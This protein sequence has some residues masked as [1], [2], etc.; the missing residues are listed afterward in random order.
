VCETLIFIL[1]FSS[2]FDEWVVL[3]D[4]VIGSASLTKVDAIV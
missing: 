1:K 4:F 3:L 2:Y